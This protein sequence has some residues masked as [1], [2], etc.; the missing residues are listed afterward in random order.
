MPSPIMNIPNM[1]PPRLPFYCDLHRDGQ[2]FYCQTCSK[3]FCVD[4]EFRFHHV[5]VTINL[6]DAIEGAGIQA[7]QVLKEARLGITILREELDAIQVSSYYN[8][9]FCNIV[10]SKIYL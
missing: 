10:A 9:Y 7:N 5:H 1:I 4:C 8:Y 2:K 6:M 3:P